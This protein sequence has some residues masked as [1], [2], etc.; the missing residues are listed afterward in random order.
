VFSS[1]S[2]RVFFQTDRGEG[3]WAIYAMQVEKIV[4]DTEASSG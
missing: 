2:Q 3:K 4:E 1:N